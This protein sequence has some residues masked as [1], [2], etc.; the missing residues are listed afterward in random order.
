MVVVLYNPCMCLMA[1]K[2]LSSYLTP[3][4]SG[5]KFRT[6]VENGEHPTYWTPFK[7]LTR[8]ESL[9]LPLDRFSDDLNY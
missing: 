1:L 7:E 3:S 9:L 5:S 4:P 6:D 8:M 2:D